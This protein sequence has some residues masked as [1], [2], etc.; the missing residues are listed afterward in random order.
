MERT[1]ESVRNTVFSLP[2]KERAHLA[3]LLISSL[4]GFDDPYECE[5]AWILEAR[6]RC[7]DFSEGR[8]EAIPEDRV[9]KE[10]FERIARTETR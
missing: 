5:K 7:Q 1:M 4:D 10:A 9:F 2:I 3:E 6:K 8:I